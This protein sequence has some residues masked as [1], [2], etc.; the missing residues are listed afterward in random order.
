MEHSHN[1]DVE[2]G[3]KILIEGN[4]FQDCKAPVSAAILKLTSGLFNVPTA[5]DAAS[6]SA[7][8]G[9][10]CQVNSL[11]GSGDFG[12][13]TDT[14]AVDAIG[15]ADS[16][17]EATSA[18]DVTA[19]KTNAGVGKLSSSSSAGG[20]AVVAPAKVVSSASPSS[21]LASS[22]A[23]SSVA[24]STKSSTSAT[25]TVA[26]TTASTKASATASNASPIASAA[27]ED[28]CV[29]AY[30]TVSPQAA[31]TSSVAAASASAS[32]VARWGRCGGNGY[33]GATSCAEGSSCTV[34]NDCEYSVG[35]P[36]WI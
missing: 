33:T 31:K 8:L 25:A 4:V 14:A 18:D 10:D 26:A 34:V 36:C 13:F 24:S 12:S 19:L 9:R 22:A 1:F 5:G 6:C 23:T 32:V 2:A 15:S 20:S 30:V 29:V 27:E 35:N 16:I 17:W 11:S 21:T 28:D 3:A 7:A